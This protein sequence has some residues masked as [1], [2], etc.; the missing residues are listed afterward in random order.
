MIDFGRTR[1]RR[2]DRL[3][4]VI[5]VQGKSKT[6]GKEGTWKT[7]CYHPKLEQSA[8]YLLQ[9]GIGDAD[10]LEGLKEAVVTARDAVLKEVCRCVSDQSKEQ[11][12]T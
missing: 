4:W 8:D 9:M 7:I 2:L 1:L 6:P 3:N 5:E 11:M 10:D 12:D